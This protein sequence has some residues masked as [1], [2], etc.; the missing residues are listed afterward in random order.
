MLEAISPWVPL[1]PG[2]PIRATALCADPT[3][4]I[5]GHA[6]VFQQC[7]GNTGVIFIFDRSDGDRT[8][9][10]TGTAVMIPAPT[11]NDDG[12]PIILPHATFSMPGTGNAEDASKYYMDGSKAGDKVAVSKLLW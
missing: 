4:S 10:A 1:T 3:E 2:T 7:P 12:E 11:Y 5:E 6:L 8:G 9:A